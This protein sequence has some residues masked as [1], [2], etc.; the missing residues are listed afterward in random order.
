[1]REIIDGAIWSIT[2]NPEKEGVKNPLIGVWQAT[3]VAGDRHDAPRV[4]IFYVFN[5]RYVK[6]LTVMLDTSR[7]N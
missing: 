3:L 1:M 2:R 5:R 4:I 7:L 6:F